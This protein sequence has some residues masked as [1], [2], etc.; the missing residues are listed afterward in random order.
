MSSGKRCGL[1]SCCIGF[2]ALI[3]Y[4]AVAIE[5]VEPTEY[6]IIKNNLTQNVSDEVLE[7]GLHWVGVFYSLIHFPSI[8]KSIEFS[9]DPIAQYKRLSTRTK[10][11]LELDISFAFQYKLRKDDLPN[12]Y[13][14]TMTEYES[15]FAKL[16]RNAILTSGGDFEAPA[17]WLNRTK[18]GD[19]MT[20]KLSDQMAAIYADVTGF[21]LLKIDLPDSYE[22]AIVK[23]QVTNQEFIT[24]TTIRQVNETQQETENIKAKGL[25]QI[26]VINANATSQ[27]T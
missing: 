15:V 6:A 23:T 4:I 25:A 19:E 9:M 26:M 24:Y 27:A 22:G 13:L 21:M 5:G 12:L 2:V 17:Y 16:A 18:V 7:G 3:V 14:N 11:G 10:E 20:Q 1:L 8:H